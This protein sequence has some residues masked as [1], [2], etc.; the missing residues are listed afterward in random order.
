ME[1][2]EH[3]TRNG[4]Y[5]DTQSPLEICKVCPSKLQLSSNAHMYLKKTVKARRKK[6]LTVSGGNHLERSHMTGNSS[7]AQL[8]RKKKNKLPYDASS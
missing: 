6:H 4:E 8:K 3:N 7:W 1:R 2:T 5:M